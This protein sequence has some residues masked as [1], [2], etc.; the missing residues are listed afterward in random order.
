MFFPLALFA[1]KKAA[2]TLLNMPEDLGNI[3]TNNFGWQASI[4]H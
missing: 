3:K 4:R 1:L 2:Q